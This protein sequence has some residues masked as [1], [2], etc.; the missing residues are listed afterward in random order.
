MHLS[1]DDMS[2]YRQIPNLMNHSALLNDQGFYDMRNALSEDADEE[3][4]PNNKKSSASVTPRYP[5]LISVLLLIL[6]CH[7]I[8]K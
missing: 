8:N 5:I 1:H 6:A 3:L 2:P 7:K 4:G